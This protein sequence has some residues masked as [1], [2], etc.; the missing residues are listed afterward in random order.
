MNDSIVMQD[1]HCLKQ[2]DANLHDLGYC[3]V[4]LVVNVLTKCKIDEFHV[5]VLLFPFK[6]EIIN[7]IF[8]VFYLPQNSLLVINLIFTTISTL[9]QVFHSH[10]SFLPPLIQLKLYILTSNFTV[11]P[12]FN[13]LCF[14]CLGLLLV[15]IL[16]LKYFNY[17]TLTLVLNLKDSLNLVFIDNIHNFPLIFSFN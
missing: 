8:I 17:W 15:H 9:F 12:F 7:Q 5:N 13:I 16:H 4:R 1:K 14:L 11:A 2:L 3:H 6:F 10:L